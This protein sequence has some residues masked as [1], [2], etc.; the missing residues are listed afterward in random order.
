MYDKWSK[1][2][3]NVFKHKHSSACPMSGT[4]TTYVDIHV[5]NVHTCHMMKYTHVRNIHVPFVN[6]FVVLSQT[7]SH[8]GIGTHLRP[9]LFH[10]KLKHMVWVSIQTLLQCSNNKFNQLW[11]YS[12]VF[13]SYKNILKSTYTNKSRYKYMY[14]Y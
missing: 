8:S 5:H 9:Y 6:P 3:L 12:R 13:Y 7:Q 14:M 2:V 1:A 11:L 10:W 4:S